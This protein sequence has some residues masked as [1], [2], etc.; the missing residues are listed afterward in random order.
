M[1]KEETSTSGLSAA[2]VLYLCQLV[3]QDSGI[4]LD[5]SKRY[6]LEG[7]LKPLSQDQG[8][9]NIDQLCQRLQ[10]DR[11]AALRTKVVEAMT[12]NETQFFRDLPIWDG[13]RQKIIP[14]LAAGRTVVHQ[15]SIWC[16]ACSSGQEPYSLAMLLK[17][18]LPNA[19]LW[20]VD[21]LGTDISA[22]MLERCRKARYAQLEVNRGLPVQNL[23]KY[24]Q[25]E[26]LEWEVKSEIRAM[27][28]FKHF[29]LNG[30]IRGL[31]VFD[32]VMCRN[33][34]IY[35]DSEMKKQVL[36]GIRSVLAPDGYLLLGGAETVYNLDD[37]FERISIGTASF[38]KLK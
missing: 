25:R 17:E 38:Y 19:S 18:I 1:V 20:N 22:A 16:A 23:V 36:A 6:L 24:F 30:P 15:L 12:T 31:G 35:F 26:H 8:L 9:S 13:L 37:H 14:E 28:R 5:E 10:A 27:T 29:N 21:I 4:V 32:L 2:N 11:Q 33:V 3:Y 34:M 7:R